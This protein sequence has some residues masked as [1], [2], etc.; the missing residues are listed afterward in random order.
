MI[1]AASDEAARILSRYTLPLGLKS[2]AANT[3]W[4][5]AE[6][7]TF[8][9]VQAG[10]MHVFITGFHVLSRLREMQKQDSSAQ[11]VAYAVMKDGWP[12][13]LAEFNNVLLS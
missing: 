9:L 1:P 6:R 8:T 2:R 13:G 10:E 4:D 11:L 12:R 5:G 3:H 7:A